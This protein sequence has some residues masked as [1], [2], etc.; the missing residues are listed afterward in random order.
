MKTWRG[1]LSNE[2]LIFM[3]NL[4]ATEG[5]FLTALL[6]SYRLDRYQRVY[7]V[8]SFDF[9]KTIKTQQLRA[10]AF[11]CALHF[12]LDRRPA[13]IAVVGSG[14]SGITAT[15]ALV[16]MGHTVTLFEK[17]PQ[18][19]PVQKNCFDRFLHPNLYD[20]PLD[21]L[22]DTLEVAGIKWV[23]GYANEV[24][25]ETEKSFNEK[26]TG[27]IRNYKPK[28]GTT[29]TDVVEYYKNGKSK[30][31]LN[32]DTAL[33]FEN[34]DAVLMTIGFGYEN[35]RPFGSRI[36]S[37]WSNSQSFYDRGSVGTPW[38]LLISG[39]G[40]GGLIE[41]LN[42]CIRE[43]IDTDVISELHPGR[44]I[45]FLESVLGR[46]GMEKF[47]RCEKLIRDRY[48]AGSDA[49]LN[50]MNIYDQQFSEMIEGSQFKLKIDKWVRN[51]T[52]VYFNSELDTVFNF[53][54]AAINRFVTYLLIRTRKIQFNTS[55]LNEDMISD[56]SN[57]PRT[58]YQ[59]KWRR[60]DVVFFDEVILRHGVDKSH[61][62]NSFPSL[63][64]GVKRIKD[65]M[66]DLRMIDALPNKI[67]DI[68]ECCNW[69]E[70]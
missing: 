64:E 48:R 55:R 5:A 66:V 47:E 67:R 33:V 40:D 54:S 62:E 34:F 41:V 2:Q 12:S 7:S 61:F 46:R 49:N 45:E 28:I 10:A 50:I 63:A 9:K 18:I 58:G 35:E 43:K 14:F 13:S 56:L 30:Y 23:A 60:N 20:W 16:S 68:I 70:I 38:K 31:T 3:S 52:K 8:G 69:N 25:S 32:S 24:V 37:Y 1:D 39:S 22:N 19:L 51:D 65:G 27:K 6:E 21:S 11:A 26:L 44:I 29:I 53:N 15:A 59:V 17:R 57:G 4:D 36:K 42:A